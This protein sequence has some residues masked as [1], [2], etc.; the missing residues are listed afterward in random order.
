MEKKIFAVSGMKCEH[1]ELSVENALKA[2]DGVVAAKADRNAKT[3]TVEYDSGKVD[4]QAMKDVVDA[5][6]RF[7]MTL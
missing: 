1:C 6:G 2:L 3:V 7:E 5:L 4:P